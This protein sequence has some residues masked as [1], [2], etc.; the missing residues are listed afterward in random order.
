MLRRL[1]PA[2]YLTATD[3]GLWG[4]LVVALSTLLFLKDI[5][6]GDKYVQQR[7]ADQELAFHKAFTIEAML[8]GIFFVLCLAMLPVF[9]LVYRTSEILLPGAILSLALP[10][11]LLGFPR[12]IFYRRMQFGRQR[13][14]EAVDPVVGLAVTIGLA[15]AG[16][17]YWSLIIGQL[18]AVA[19]AGIVTQ[20]W[21][22]YRMRFRYDRG[23]LRSYFSFSWPLFVSQGTNMATVQ[24]T[25]I[26]GKASVGLS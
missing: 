2:A 9:A 8:T 3:Y 5:G 20:L 21:S 12:M 16:F 18:V 22:P 10:L 23:T 15:I 7:E 17:G 13:A 25:T 26:A 6:I 11:S 14:L 19:A 24:A 1:L 4:I